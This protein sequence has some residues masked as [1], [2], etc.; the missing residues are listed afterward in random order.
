MHTWI[1]AGAFALMWN[2]QA[3]LTVLCVFG[4]YTFFPT[5]MTCIC[6]GMHMGAR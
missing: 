3:A 2:W 4:A 6:T 1:C 5:C